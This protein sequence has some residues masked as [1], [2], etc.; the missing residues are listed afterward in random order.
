MVRSQG[1]PARVVSGY[2]GGSW[3]ASDKSY[4][5]TNNMA[6]LW[7]E[8]YFPDF[9]WITFDPAPALSDL[10]VSL[11][12][13]FQ[14]TLAKYSLFARIV[15]LQYVV[16][17]SPGESFVVLRDQAFQ[18]IGDLFSSDSDEDV[19]QGKKTM[20]VGMR[21]VLPGL[22]IFTLFGVLLLFFYRLISDRQ[23]VSRHRLTVEQ[24]HAKRLYA[25][26]VKKLEGMGIA[27]RNRT[28]EEL[29]G[30]VREVSDVL[31]DELE[32]F[33]RQYHDARFGSRGMTSEELARY[34]KVI[35]ELELAK[36]G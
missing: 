3:D 17:Y 2:R 22:L 9:G 19:V 23:S 12:E 29:M 4:T 25:L 31:Y 20:S 10:D 33:V 5:I 8:V 27:C 14:N 7:V 24:E 13:S 6:H 34:K 11:L 35:R 30:R 26:L 18:V 21:G 36:M 1:I 16:G 15:W 28:A 32:P